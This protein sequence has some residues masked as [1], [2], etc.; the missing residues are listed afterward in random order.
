MRRISSLFFLTLIFPAFIWAEDIDLTGEAA[1][2]WDQALVAESELRTRD[3]LQILLEVEKLAPD[4]SKVLQ[5]IA[6][7]YSDSTVDTDDEDA[8]RR[9]LDK[10]LEY[11][12][13]ATDIDPED[14]VNLLSLAITQ[15]KMATLEGNKAKVEAARVIKA[16]ARVIK[17][18]AREAIALDP[19]YAWAH[20]V[21]GRWHREVDELGSIARFFTKI[22]YGG[23]PEA[24]IEDAVYH[25]EKAAELEPENLNHHLELGFA[26]AAAGEKDRARE[27]LIRGLQMPSREKHD[28][29]AKIRAQ[30]ML[31]KIS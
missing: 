30:R 23:L 6:R 7:Q 11:S 24:S 5:K 20:H 31:D 25:L 2:R 14:P 22:L 9:L 29:A 12:Q 16:N 3:A 17:A 26:Y 1:E 18:N 4:N 19:S 8:Q 15:G 10:A 13:R 21:L 28:E 27:R